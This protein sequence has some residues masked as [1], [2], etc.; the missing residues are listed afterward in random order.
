MTLVG[1]SI[2]VVL[3]GIGVWHL[4]G[5]T[6]R[7]EEQRVRS[8]EKWADELYAAAHALINAD[9]EVARL[10]SRLMEI[11]AKVPPETGYQTVR[12]IGLG[13]QM[14]QAILLKL[15]QMGLGERLPVA[16]SPEAPSVPLPTPLAPVSRR[17]PR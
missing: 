10:E 6:L 4:I 12:R 8:F 11:I 17:R 1:L 15:E 3:A 9:M 5:I 2:L 7:R 16:P 13:R 14:E